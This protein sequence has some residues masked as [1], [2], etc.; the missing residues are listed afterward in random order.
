MLPSWWTRRGTKNRPSIRGRS[1]HSA[2]AGRRQH[3]HGRPLIDLNVQVAMGDEVIEP[4]EL[5]E[6][7]DLKVPLVRFRGQWVEIQRRR[8]SRRPPTFWRNRDQATPAGRHPHRAGRRPAG[9]SR[10]RLPFHHRLAQGLAGVPSAEGQNRAVGHARRVQRRT[11][12]VP[13]A[14][15]T[16]GSIFSAGGVSAPAWPT[17]WASA[18]RSRPWPPF[19]GD[20]Q[21]GN[22]KPSLLVCPTSVIN[23][24]Q[25]E[26]QKF[27]PSLPVM[28]HHG[29]GRERGEQFAQQ[30]RRPPAR[31]HQLRHHDAGPRTA[32]FRRL[33]I[34]HP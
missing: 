14:G 23:N 6:L 27:T 4:E 31:N 13:A 25:R 10:Q 18:R 1:P 16:R 17:T 15:L 2:H 26:A 24:W 29:P 20:H 5:F 22:E 33:A 30:G 34:R 19:C 3:D 9:G 8:N 28:L 32:G 11:T 12:S 21:Q 7:A